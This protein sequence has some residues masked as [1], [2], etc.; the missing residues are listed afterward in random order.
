[1]AGKK[2]FRI[3][4]KDLGRVKL[5]LEEDGTEVK[6]ELLKTLGENTYLIILK[7]GECWSPGKKMP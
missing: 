7:P 2:S 5:V 3:E 4:K 1:M 6:E